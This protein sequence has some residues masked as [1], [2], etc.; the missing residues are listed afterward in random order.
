MFPPETVSRR[1]CPKHQVIVVQPCKVQLD[2]EL[3]PMERGPAIKTVARYL[4]GFDSRPAP[5]T[6]AERESFLAGNGPAVEMAK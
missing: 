3:V 6:E 5:L 4:G 1:I 2:A